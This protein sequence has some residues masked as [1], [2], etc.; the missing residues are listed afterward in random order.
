SAIVLSFHHIIFDG[1]S[2]GVFM[3]ELFE[4][5]ALF[6]DG[7]GAAPAALPIQYG[8]YAEWQN[9]WFTG[10]VRDGQTQYWKERL[11]GPLP[12][13]ELPTDRRRPDRQTF[14][15]AFHNLILSRPL[16]DSLKELSRT[17]KTTPFTAFLALFDILL[18]RYTGLEDIIVG[19]P[20]AGRNLSE[21]EPLIGV[22]V[23]TLPVRTRMPPRASFRDILRNVRDA[24]LDAFAHGDLAFDAI[25]EAVQ[26][27]RI[28]NNNP[29]F[30]V[31]YTYQNKLEP[32]STAGLKVDYEIV[33]GGTAKFDLSLDVFE[34]PQG[35]TCIFEYNTGLFDRARIERMAS[36]FEMLARSVIE[37]PDQPVSTLQMLTPGELDEV[38]KGAAQVSEL[39]PPHDVV[40]LIERQAAATPEA[41][42]VTFEGASIS[43]GELNR[44]ANRL[45]RL[46]RERG[47]GAGQVVGVCLDRS[48]PLIT[49]L[50]AILK[51]RAAFV[52]MDPEFPAERLAFIAEDTAAVLL[53]SEGA[54]R[55]RL[56]RGPID[57]LCLEDAGQQM[58]AHP[59]GNLDLAIGGDDPAYVV[60]TSGTTGRPKGIRIP[61]RS[62]VNA[63]RGWEREY[64]LEAG[65]AHLQMASFQFD[66]FCGDFI[67]A[68]GSGGK[69]TLCPR[70]LFA[71]PERLYAL[72]SGEGVACAEFVPAVF[73][74]L[75]DHLAATGRRLDFVKV[76]IVASDS[77]Y[78]HEYQEYRR[79]C[80]PET[81][82]IN[83]YG[84]AEATI[85]S[86][87]FEGDLSGLPAGQL[88][89]IGKPF[90]N[91][92]VYVLDANLQ[93]MP[94]GVP[95]ELC[96]GGPGVAEGYLNQPELTSAKFVPNP[97]RPGSG[98]HLYRTGDIGRLGPGNQFE[99]IGRRDHQVKIRGMRI[100]LGE[101]ETALL[102]HPAVRECVATVRD[103]APNEKRIVAYLVT[104]PVPDGEAPGIDPESLRQHLATIIPAYMVP[105]AYVELDA[106]PL[107]RN[108]KVDRNA[109][110]A[111]ERHQSHA[112]VSPRTLVEEMLASIWCQ[113]FSLNR[114]SVHESFFSLGGHSLLAVQVIS[115]ARKIFQVDL[116]LSYLF[117]YPTIAGLAAVIADL[118]GKGSEYS[119]TINALP[120]ITPDP[121]GRYEP[122]ALTEV[123][124]AYWLG[125]NEIF[126]FGNVT[127]HSYDEMET[128]HMDV[129]KFEKAWNHLVRRHDMLRAVVRPDGLQEIL[130]DVPNYPIRVLDLRGRSKEEVDAGIDGVRAEMS[131]QML[132]VYRWPVFD[133]RVTLLDDAKARIHFSTDA[134]IFDVWSFV[135]LIEE[136]IKLYL[137][138]GAELQPLELSFRDYVIAENSLHLTERYARALEYWQRRVP[139][140]APAP[141]LPMAMNPALLKKPRFTRLHAR[142]EP[143]AWNR[144]KLKATS[145]GMT[146][147]GIMLAAYAE[148]LTQYSRSPQFSLNLTF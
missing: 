31:L 143:E 3:K 70:D 66:V 2:L 142:L 42:A 41:A 78:V 90:A 46:L 53:V 133:I 22:F 74:S 138:R 5:Y 112:F 146:A 103:D 127:T 72:M 135:I 75:A 104:D 80:G 123:Q 38:L 68:L 93:P 113:V 63:Y 43:Y 129:P 36:H 124:Q 105:N 85:D 139:S 55:P 118:Q 82:L 15:G 67:R 28:T 119:D 51:A 77:W 140:L 76:L 137:D 91:V 122:F 57:L 83:S 65:W 147:T 73:R 144:L 86:T 89:P 94:L 50:L 23:N 33:D 84:L 108:G 44:Q 27:E 25:V 120:T 11:A 14:D 37:N 116:S 71:D 35:P 58:A 17:E 6:R 48:I 62:L 54:H 16:F 10:D 1:W 102:K 136:L 107:S 117:Q 97:F 59:D 134:L 56:P 64:R 49:T 115:R 95:G 9:R 19:T 92:E 24:S 106:L 126:E 99:L 111:P 121:S 21:T 52:A 109:L 61:H 141:D 60:Y 4:H 148:I 32:L 79:L 13:L 20:V 7:K 101:I 125:R 39:P 128:V 96:I 87:Y 69:L 98:G 26:P 110:P 114:V 145:A 132:D 12:L 8:D 100:E 81:R 18:A 40:G 34:G 29:I 47:V 131:H 88:V 30:Q 45:A 130:Q